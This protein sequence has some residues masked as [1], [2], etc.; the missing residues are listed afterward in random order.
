VSLI[1]VYTLWAG[2]PDETMTA[3][4]E[5]DDLSGECLTAAHEALRAGLAVMIKPGMMTAEEY[6]EGPRSS[7]APFLYRYAA[8]VV[9]DGY[10]S[11]ADRAWLLK[12]HLI[13]LTSA[14]A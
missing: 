10:M 8:A 12:K 4:E 11:P 7:D 5:Y 3:V 13:T 2:L 9:A 14:D 1:V 6:A